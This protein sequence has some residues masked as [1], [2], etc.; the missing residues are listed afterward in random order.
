MEKVITRYIVVLLFQVWRLAKDGS[1]IQVL[2]DARNDIDRP[3]WLWSD[4]KGENLTV[5]N[6]DGQE[7]R[8]YNI[9]KVIRFSLSLL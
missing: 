3:T 1:N 7:I 2:L 5:I 8:N 9:Y 6:K 4:K